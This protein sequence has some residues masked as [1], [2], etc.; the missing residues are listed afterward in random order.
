MMACDCYH[1]PEVW[2]NFIFPGHPCLICLDGR[3]MSSFSS[4][5]I[6][7][8][9]HQEQ[10]AESNVSVHYYVGTG[11]LTKHPLQ[12]K[13][14]LAEQCQSEYDSALKLTTGEPVTL[15]E[16]SLSLDISFSLTFLV[17]KKSFIYK[18]V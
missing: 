15:E 6:L 13:L 7:P 11:N 17:S 8:C 5:L 14:F 3:R 1:L 2:L 9:L 10:A 16:G 18:L 12:I 4:S